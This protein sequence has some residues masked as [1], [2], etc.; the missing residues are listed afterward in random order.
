[1]DRIRN[2]NSGT[3]NVGEFDEVTSLTLLDNGCE[4]SGLSYLKNV[5]SAVLSGNQ[6]TTTDDFKKMTLLNSIDLSKNP[7]VNVNSLAGMTSLEMVDLSETKL[8]ATQVNYL[9]ECLPD[10]IIIGDNLKGTATLT[11]QE[12]STKYS[13]AKLA[14]EYSGISNVYESGYIL[15]ETGE[16]FVLEP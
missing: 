13:S 11:V 2:I 10:A 15:N 14:V 9:K 1:M 5:T 6:F 4:F 7:L 3:V 12:E 16:L 8:S